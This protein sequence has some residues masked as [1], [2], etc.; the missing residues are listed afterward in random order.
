MIRLSPLG[1]IGEYFGLYSTFQKAASITAPLLR[2]GITLWLIQYPVFKYQVAWAAMTI[3]LIVWTILM[4][5]V[6][7][8]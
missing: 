7:E 6:K 8:H 5:R 3:L 1:E 2:W 4:M